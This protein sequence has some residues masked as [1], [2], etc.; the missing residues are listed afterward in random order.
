MKL[1]RPLHLLLP[2][3]VLF[4]ISGSVRAQDFDADSIYYTPLARPTTPAPTVER[5]VK[6]FRDTTKSGKFAGYYFDLGMGMLTGCKDCMTGTEFTFSAAT[7][8]GV[9]LGKKTRVGIGAGFDNYVGWKALPLFG[10]VSYDLAGT[11]NT[12]AIFV[13]TQYGYGWVWRQLQPFEQAEQKG[14]PVFAALMGYRVRYHDL[15]ISLSAGFKQQLATTAFL[16]DTW[17]PNEK[18]EMVKGTPNR[19]TVETKLGRAV[20][21]LAFSWR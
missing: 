2:F 1:F 14:G 11:K 4:L 16:F 15:R 19:T 18:G 9:T 13:Q 7:T 12:H 17:H 3:S 21:T 20:F 5:N 8:H 10:S 6:V